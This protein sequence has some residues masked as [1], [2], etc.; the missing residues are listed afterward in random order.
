M[1]VVA[2]ANWATVAHR[3]RGGARA[4]AANPSQ[5]RALDAAQPAPIE[6]PA[7]LVG[8]HVRNLFTLKSAVGMC[9]VDMQALGEALC[10]KYGADAFKNASFGEKSGKPIIS[11]R[12]E[13]PVV[14]R[15]LQDGVKVGTDQY[16]IEEVPGYSSPS[17]LRVSLGDWTKY[18]ND[19]EA[20][21]ELQAILDKVDV[22]GG[23]FQGVD[24]RTPQ[25]SAC[26]FWN[27]QG[28]RPDRAQD[29]RGW[30]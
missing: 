29:P 3:G 24:A 16:D 7:D 5:G 11:I 28:F 27:F 6:V 19:D 22:A 23:R 8:G 18:G 4:P 17:L 10:A 9:R 15:F 13:A 21:Q 26:S 25:G 2:N 12:A 14:A 20:R 1:P 30:K